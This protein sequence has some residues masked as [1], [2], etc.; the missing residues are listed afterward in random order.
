MLLVATLVVTCSNDTHYLECRRELHFY[1][2]EKREG[3]RTFFDAAV[4]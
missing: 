3:V 1:N 4:G 2:G